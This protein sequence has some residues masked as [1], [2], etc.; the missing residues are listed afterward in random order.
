[1]NKALEWNKTSTKYSYDDRIRHQFRDNL[2][3]AEEIV[4]EKWSGWGEGEEDR[5]HYERR[6]PWTNWKH[7]VKLV[8]FVKGWRKWWKQEE[9]KLDKE[10]EKWVP[11]SS[12]QQMIDD[13]DASEVDED[14]E[15]RIPA[16]K[17]RGDGEK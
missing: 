5:V 13:E 7:Q 2:D 9:E 11:T 1:M 6:R 10:Q 4:R 14:D 15:E 16:T 17:K 12:L 3:L 8:E